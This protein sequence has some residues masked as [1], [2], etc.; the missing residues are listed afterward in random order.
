MPTTKLRSAST[1]AI[2][3]TAAWSWASGRSIRVISSTRPSSPSRSTATPSTG[4]SSTVAAKNVTPSSCRV[5]ST[6]SRIP[7]I[8]ISRSI[9]WSR[10][11]YV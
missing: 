8:A 5:T 1:R 9:T 6:F 10:P 11:R 7:P 2:L 3:A 4:C